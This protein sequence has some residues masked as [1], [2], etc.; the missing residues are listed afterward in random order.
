[1]LFFSMMEGPF[2][3]YKIIRSGRVS[4]ILMNQI[5]ESNEKPYISYVA[6]VN[7]NRIFSYG[8]DACG[9]SGFHKLQNILK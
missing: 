3:F 8:K 5:C 1:M 4:V 2:R 7:Q 6:L 9:F